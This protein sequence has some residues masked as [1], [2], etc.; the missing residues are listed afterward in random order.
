MHYY[1]ILNGF[2]SD[3]N[4]LFPSTSSCSFADLVLNELIFSEVLNGA[5]KAQIFSL[6]PL[7]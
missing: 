3:E 6:H 5:F 7:S 1:T 4:G 2:T